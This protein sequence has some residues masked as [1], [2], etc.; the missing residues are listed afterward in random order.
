MIDLSAVEAAARRIAPHLRRTPL[1]DAGPLPGGPAGGRLFLKLENLQVTGSFKS[2]GAA[3]KVLALPREQVRRGLV[4]ASGGNHG[5]GV[6]F[7][8]KL[9]EAPVS[10]YL[11]ANVPP[12]KAAKLER[13]GARVLWEGEIWDDANRGRP[14]GRPPRGADLRPP[15]R[16]RG[17]DRRPGDPRPGGPRRRAPPRPLP[18]GDRRRRVDLRRRH[19]G[20]RAASGGAGDRD[21]GRRR[22]QDPPEPAR[23]PADRAPSRSRPP[24]PPWP[25]APAT[26]STSRSSARGWTRSSW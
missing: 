4:T 15:L 26:R 7:A 19:G 9:V 2:R 18:G 20:Q 3:N 11:P 24:P 13:W 21:R 10:I 23:R 8:G 25:P 14:G 22:P 5:L 1:L 12:A 6:A 16:R 17:G